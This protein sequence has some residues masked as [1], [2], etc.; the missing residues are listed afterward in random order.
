[1]DKVTECLVTI[2]V[3]CNNAEKCCF[4]GKS[5]ELPVLEDSSTIASPMTEDVTPQSSELELWL[6][7]QGLSFDEVKKLISGTKKKKDEEAPV[8]PTG[9]SAEVEPVDMQE[10]PKIPEESAEAESTMALESP[11]VPEKEVPAESPKAPAVTKTTTG[12][13]RRQTAP[14]NKTSKKAKKTPL[15]PSPST[16]KALFAQQNPLV[17]ASKPS[18]TNHGYGYLKEFTVS[19][20]F[21]KTYKDKQEFWPKI[22]VSCSKELVGEATHGPNQYRVTSKTK[23][24][25]CPCAEMSHKECVHAVCGPCYKASRPGTGTP[26]EAN[27]RSR[28]STAKAKGRHLDL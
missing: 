14:G 9:P 16:D 19:A 3:F 28:R 5:I 4:A 8:S 12:K 25:L 15:P 24:H 13:K 23:A 11:K 10:S 21:N 7:R 6:K 2:V 17:A 18:C 1:M 20:Y 22:C 27:K 26:P